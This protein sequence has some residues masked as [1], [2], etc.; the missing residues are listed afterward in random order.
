MADKK[1]TNLRIR[2]LIHYFR[3]TDSQFAKSIKV[4]Q[5]NLSAILSGKRVAGEAIVNKICMSFDKVNKDWLLDGKGKMFKDWDH[6][7]LDRVNAILDNESMSMKDFYKSLGFS[8]SFM[9]GAYQM[10]SLIDDRMLIKVHDIYPKYSLNWLLTGRGSMLNDENG[11]IPKGNIVY[12]PHVQKSDYEKYIANHNN[13]D[14]LKELDIY[15]VKEF[16]VTYESD[17]MAF[18]VTDNSM[19]VGNVRFNVSTGDVV[20]G[21]NINRDYSK[22]SSNEIYVIVTNKGIFVRSCMESSDDKLILSPGDKILFDDIVIDKNDVL[23]LY[24]IYACFVSI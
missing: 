15:P 14:Y 23:E 8:E 9:I 1:S 3:M 10:G 12:F 20:I 5:G 17:K 4:D 16:P 7:V 19:R 13:K 22:L 2:E 24:H 18:D 21:K 6:S 11:K